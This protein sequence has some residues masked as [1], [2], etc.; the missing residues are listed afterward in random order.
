MWC[1]A[2]LIEELDAV[3]ASQNRGIGAPGIPQ[4]SMTA[5]TT[6][7]PIPS[8]APSTTTPTVQAIDNQDSQRWMR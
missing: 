8:I 3:G 6:A 7:K 2:A 4:N 1:I 5:I